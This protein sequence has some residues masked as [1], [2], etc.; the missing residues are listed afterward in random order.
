MIV[1]HVSNARAVVNLRN[2]SAGAPILVPFDLRAP[3]TPPLEP[4]RRYVSSVTM[5]DR[6]LAITNTRG[7]LR[8]SG[9]ST[10]ATVFF[11]NI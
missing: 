4:Q 8:V 5:D 9:Q 6:G 7:F 3:A 2:G 11:R 10:A 1:T